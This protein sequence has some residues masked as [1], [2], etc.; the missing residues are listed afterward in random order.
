MPNKRI[1]VI[2]YS[3]TGFTKKV[4]QEIAKRFDC[5][6]E[7]IQEKANRKGIIG[8]IL[9]GRDA[10]QKRRTN[11][12]PTSKNISDYDLVIMGTPV[13]AYHITPALRTFIADNK[14]KFKNVALFSTQ[15]GTSN[16]KVLE[17]H[18][19]LFNKKPAAVLKVTGK[20]FKSED[21]IKS[22]EIFSAEILKL[23]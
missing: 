5:E 22:V 19:E 4:A 3:R 8:F 20:D 21:Y 6:I 15:G 12:H 9:G 2:Y 18:L 16:S 1:L 7:E 13:W 10:L 23:G 14:G 11:I 17:D